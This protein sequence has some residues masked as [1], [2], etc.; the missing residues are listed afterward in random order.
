MPFCNITRKVPLE[1]QRQN[2]EVDGPTLPR[3]RQ[4]CI[5][6]AEVEYLSIEQRA[7]L[8]VLQETATDQHRKLSFVACCCLLRSLVMVR[9]TLSGSFHAISIPF[10]SF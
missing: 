5:F 9:T 2:G 4:I 6:Y 8:K 1:P 10:D 7:K 3:G